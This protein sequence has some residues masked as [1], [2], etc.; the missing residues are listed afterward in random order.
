MITALR[1]EASRLYAVWIRLGANATA[2][3]CSSSSSD[4]VLIPLMQ[5]ESINLKICVTVA[6]VIVIV[7]GGS[8]ELR[9]H[10]EGLI[11]LRSQLAVLPSKIGN[12]KPTNAGGQHLKTKDTILDRNPTTKEN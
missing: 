11:S 2:M 6:V 9:T 5:Y 7:V 3:H 4:R 1:S 8:N 10:H 12:L